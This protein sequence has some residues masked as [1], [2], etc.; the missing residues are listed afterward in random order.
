MSG[1]TSGVVFTSTG[2]SSDDL[3]FRIF[4]GKTVSFEIIWGGSSPIDITGYSSS[5]Q[6]RASRD[7]DLIF[8]FSTTNGRIAIDGPA[9]KL[10]FSATDTETAVIDRDGIYEVELVNTGGDVFRVISG[11]FRPI[12]D[13]VA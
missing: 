6:I 4:Q 7:R 11:T 8:E 3:N 10:T 5:L 12:L 2:N 1:T 9:G 13:I